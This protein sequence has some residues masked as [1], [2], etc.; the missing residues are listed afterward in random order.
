MLKTNKETI[1]QPFNNFDI[2]EILNYRDG[3]R[4]N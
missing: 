4:C 3:G 1:A 2:N